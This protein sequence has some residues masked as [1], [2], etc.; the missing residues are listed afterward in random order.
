MTIKLWPAGIVVLLA[1]FGCRPTDV[2]DL[3]TDADR[4]NVLLIMADDLGYGDIGAFNPDS[5]IPTPYMDRLAAE[6]MR[7]TDAH[8]A[9]AVCT[10]S[11]YA[12]LTGRYAWRHPDLTRGVTNGYS[13]LVADTTRVT[14]AS[15]LSELG[16]T[17][18]VIGKWHLGLG[19]TQPTDYTQPLNPGPQ[20]LGFGYFHGIPASLD[21][22]PYVWVENS[23]VVTQPTSHGENPVGCCTGAFW[24]PGPMAP[25]FDHSQ[26]LPVIAERTAQYLRD[27]AQDGHP[28]FLY[29]PLAAPHTPWL[30]AEEFAGSTG[31]GEYGD[32]TAQVDASVGSMVAALDESGLRENTIV[33]VTSDNGAYWSPRDIDS[34]G[35]RANHMWRGMKA[36]IHEGGHRI[37]LIIRWPGH[38][39]A[40]TSTDQLMVHTDLFATLAEAAGRPLADQEAE[41]SF[42][43]LSVLLGNTAASKRTSAVHQ[44]IHGMLALRQD[45]WKYIAGKGSGGFTRVDTTAGGPPGQ[46]YDL[47]ADPVESFNLYRTQPAQAAA[48]QAALT[49]IKE[50]GR[51][52][53]LTP[54]NDR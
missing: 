25:D 3:E 9:S 22:P 39:P 47:A 7:F 43:L 6:G 34:L 44:S 40:G 37:P 15:A 13:P 8:S 52:R 33:I 16:Y 31:A 19:Q 45:H 11:R 12:L 24:R 10:P 46:L 53:P 32:F 18:A 23:S 42:S 17:T 48:M 35:H 29:V 4:P 2:P 30:P 41:D 36:D 38:A 26:V 51:S 50:A 14:I 27:R 20:A 54:T 49:A 21:M 28:F 5:K 1:A